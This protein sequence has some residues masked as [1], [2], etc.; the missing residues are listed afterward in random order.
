MELGPKINFSI[1]TEVASGEVLLFELVVA[2]YDV[3]GID[4]CVFEVFLLEFGLSWI[5]SVRN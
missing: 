3:M 5:Q 4:W 1:Y 2:G